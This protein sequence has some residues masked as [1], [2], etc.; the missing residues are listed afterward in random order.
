MIIILVYLPL[1]A[2]AVIFLSCK[3]NWHRLAAKH[4]IDRVLVRVHTYTGLK[5]VHLDLAT[6]HV[7]TVVPRERQ[8]TDK[9]IES[10]PFFIS[11]GRSMDWFL[12]NQWLDQERKK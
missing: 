12:F 9:K 1:K 2:A 6:L 10:L 3:M 11:C 7:H 4:S 8:K 5:Y